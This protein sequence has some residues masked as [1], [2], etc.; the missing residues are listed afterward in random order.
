MRKTK[1]RFNRKPSIIKCL[2]SILFVSFLISQNITLAQTSNNEKK[3]TYEESKEKILEKQVQ[4]KEEMK[5]VKAAIDLKIQG[6]PSAP[7]YLLEQKLEILKKID[8]VYEQQLFETK[9]SFDLMQTLEQLREELS[10]IVVQRTM[11]EPPYSFF[12]SFR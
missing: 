3:S 11:P 1:K 4:L 2:Y 8:L 9:R 7:S 6:E 5:K 12:L 10:A